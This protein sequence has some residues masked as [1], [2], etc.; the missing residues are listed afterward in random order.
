MIEERYNYGGASDVNKST[1][2]DVIAEEADLSKSAAARALEAALTA[3]T[4]ALRRG[5]AVSISG[6]G[7]F[8]VR[9]RGARTARN[10][11]TGEAIQV[12]ASRA[13][14]F[15]PGKALKDALN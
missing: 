15:K 7:T 4:D 12:A 14:A 10:P 9:E 11:R 5:E 6:F 8:S 1:L 13:A 2:V 3:L